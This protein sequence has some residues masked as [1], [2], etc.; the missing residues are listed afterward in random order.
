MKLTI[1][2]TARMI[3]VEGQPLRIWAGADENGTEVEVMVRAVSPQ[4]HDLAR[5]AAFEAELKELPQLRAGGIDYRFL[6]D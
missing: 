3:T 1:S 4:T 2:P 6:V 5:L